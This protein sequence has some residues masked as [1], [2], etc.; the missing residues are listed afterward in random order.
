MFLRLEPGLG[1]HGTLYFD[2]MLSN[3]KAPDS[4]GFQFVRP[5]FFTRVRLYEC[6]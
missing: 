2:S 1:Q 6:Y 3:P 5:N 4:A